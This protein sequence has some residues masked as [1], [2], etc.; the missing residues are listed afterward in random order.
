MKSRCPGP[1]KEQLSMAT[2]SERL[3]PIDRGKLLRECDDEE[4]F[5]N[6]CLHVYIRDT[7]LDINCIAAALDRNDFS[8]IAA[9]AHR[10]KG[11][12]AS[13]RAEFLR[14][15]AARLEDLGGKGAI[16]AAGECFDRL[17]VEF[18]KFKKFIAALPPFPG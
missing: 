17:Q 12:S 4:S 2:K 8:S 11:A 6:R 13:I 18:E 5:A 1:L 16:T 3:H 15:Q 9:L 10:I 7:Q 14:Q